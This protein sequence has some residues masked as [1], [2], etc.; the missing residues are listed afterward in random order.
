MKNE[1]RLRRLIRKIV[2]EEIAKAKQEHLVTPPPDEFDEPRWGFFDEPEL[3]SMY[4]KAEKDPHHH[5][6]DWPE[7]H[8]E[9]FGSPPYIPQKR[10]K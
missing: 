3:E 6:Q 2:K 7:P 1:A 8:F 10:K 9:E 5:P 4:R